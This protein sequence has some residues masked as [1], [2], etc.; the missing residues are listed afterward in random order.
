MRVTVPSE[1]RLACAAA[2]RAVLF[3]GDLDAASHG[4]AEGSQRD[5]VADA[6][7]AEMADAIRAA[8]LSTGSNITRTRWAASSAMAAEHVGW[9]A[10]CSNNSFV[11]RRGVDGADGALLEELDDLVDRLSTAAGRKSRPTAAPLVVL[12]AKDH[13]YA[14]AVRRLQLLAAPT[15][16]L[17]PGRYIAA[18][19][20]RAACAVTPLTRPLAA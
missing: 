11:V 6:V 4:L 10:R 19:L 9:L 7:L 20:Y 13:I 16:V 17:Q 1:V 15:W 5:R 8:V 12:V 3:L 2:R 18:D 14:P